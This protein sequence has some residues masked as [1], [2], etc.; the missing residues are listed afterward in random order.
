MTCKEKKE[1]EQKLEETGGLGEVSWLSL[2]LLVFLSSPLLLLVGDA[3]RKKTLGRKVGG[4]RASE[5]GLRAGAGEGS[6]VGR[7]G[8]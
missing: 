2:F 8:S 6:G 7:G 1:G 5:Q 3:G 4:E